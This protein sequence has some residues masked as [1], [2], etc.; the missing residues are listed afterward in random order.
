M[1]AAND[2]LVLAVSFTGASR[3]GAIFANPGEK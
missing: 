2:P 1:L 3:F